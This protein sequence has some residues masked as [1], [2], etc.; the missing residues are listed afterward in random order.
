MNSG[1]TGEDSRKILLMLQKS[2][3]TPVEVGSFSCYLQGFNIHPYKVSS[4]NSSC[5]DSI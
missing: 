3:E 4:I 1:D 5:N 2:G